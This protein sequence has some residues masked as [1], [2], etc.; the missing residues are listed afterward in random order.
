[1]TGGILVILGKT[2]RNFAAGMSGGIA[3]IYDEDDSFNNKCNKAMV[4][5]ETLNRTNLNADINDDIINRDLLDFDELRLKKIIQNHI[6]STN[7]SIAENIIKNWDKIIPKFKKVT[8]IEFKRVLE[9]NKKENLTK[10][11]GE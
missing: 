3:Y 5:I 1:M 4:E 11:A 2:G 6:K 8:P 9:N 10:V 7:S